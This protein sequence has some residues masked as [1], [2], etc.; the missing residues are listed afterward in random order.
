MSYV[1]EGLDP[2]PFQMFFDM[3]EEELATLNACI[4]VA[5]S[6]SGYPCRASVAHAEIGERLLLINHE[7]LPGET[8]YRASHAIFIRESATEK[9]TYKDETPAPFKSRMLSLRAFDQGH[10]MLDARLVD[11]KICDQTLLE[12]FENSDIEFVHIHYAVRGCYAAKAV[13]A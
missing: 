6:L 7:H 3:N 5:D 9:A 10:M 1:I 8:P 12:L 13:R 2:A 4:M 11:G